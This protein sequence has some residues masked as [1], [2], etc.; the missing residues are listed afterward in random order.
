MPYSTDKLG[1]STECNSSMA[2][3]VNYQDP[4]AIEM[5]NINVERRSH[6]VVLY[7]VIR[8]DIDGVEMKLLFAGLLACIK[9]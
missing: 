5:F 9:Y 8:S 6:C 1:V 7:G 3:I 4:A 2:R